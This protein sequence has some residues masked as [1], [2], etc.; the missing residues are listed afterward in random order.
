MNTCPVV[1][2]ELIDKLEKEQLKIKQE[3]QQTSV[4]SSSKM[5]NSQQK[6]LKNVMSSKQEPFIPSHHMPMQESQK[7]SVSLNNSS[8]KPILLQNTSQ[9]NKSVNSSTNCHISVTLSQTCQA[10][11]DLPL[12]SSDQSF[13]I[14]S[15]DGSELIQGISSLV[16]TM[17]KGSAMLTMAQSIQGKDALAYLQS[18]LLSE[19]NTSVEDMLRLN[20]ST[21]EMTTSSTM[22]NHGLQNSS[23]ECLSHSDMKLELNKQQQIES[24]SNSCQDTGVVKASV[25][26]TY[27]EQPTNSY[28][29]NAI[30][31]QKSMDNTSG[32][33]PMLNS[34]CIQEHQSSQHSLMPL[35]EDTEAL[36]QSK[37]SSNSQQTQNKGME[38]LNTLPPPMLI[39]HA[40][41]NTTSKK[42]ENSPI[43]K[44]QK[45]DLK[46]KEQKGESK[47]DYS[48]HTTIA[49]PGM[50]LVYNSYSCTIP[51]AEKEPELMQDS[52][53]KLNESSTTED[54]NSDC[55][56]ETISGQQI[57]MELTKEQLEKLKESSS[58][59]L[60]G[61]PFKKLG[62]AALTKT[63]KPI[64]K[65][66]HYL[67]RSFMATKKNT[68][69]SVPK[70][71][72]KTSYAKM[73]SLML[74]RMHAAKDVSAG[75]AFNF[76]DQALSF[77]QAALDP[78]HIPTYRCDGIVDSTTDPTRTF[79]SYSNVSIKLA[80]FNW[81]NYTNSE[82]K[83][84]TPSSPS[85][86]SL[87]FVQAGIPGVDL[88][89]LAAGQVSSTPL[90]GYFV[91]TN[92]I[93]SYENRYGCRLVGRSMTLTNI[94][95]Q[96]YRGGY[97]PCYS[98]SQTVKHINVGD[99]ADYDQWF[100]DLKN[101]AQNTVDGYEASRGVYAVLKPINQS[102]YLQFNQ[103]DDAEAFYFSYPSS[104]LSAADFPVNLVNAATAPKWL[105][106]NANIVA[107]QP[108]KPITSFNDVNWNISVKYSSLIEY[109]VPHALG[110]D[111]VINYPPALS[112][113]FG[114][115]QYL[116][117]FYPASY[118]DFAQLSKKILE[119]YNR[120]SQF[121]DA[122]AGV[123]PNGSMILNAAKTA[124]GLFARTGRKQLKRTI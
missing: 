88:I 84:T 35:K 73:S 120:N 105:A 86:D 91:V 53:N 42:K 103:I 59:G 62:M 102:N 119:V 104:S 65:I 118:N 21:V 6:E 69:K 67:S 92:N 95:E 19:S 110:T 10:S 15:S 99:A 112:V 66:L 2:P 17:A 101:I 45:E 108:P 33:K 29:V 96:M 100:I 31:P 72:R 75:I 27:Q 49:A 22:I 63:T 34:A 48:T 123:I 37:L 13:V 47:K 32:L 58:I 71:T 11:I 46:M 9:I 107:Y 36:D 116:P 76:P 40:T 41:Q 77:I 39:P 38:S 23:P 114:V 26:Q 122:I 87:Y 82:W 80:E 64:S 52:N 51:A 111:H 68:K 54:Q 56:V 50:P 124:L 3:Q 43:L 106:W 30:Q 74:S 93:K 55:V 79:I 115:N 117:G 70:N 109:R 98:T 97:F 20:T 4:P 28:V 60:K 14:S 85:I 89:V 61:I 78:A 8:M 24:L 94:G 12:Q 1:S 18:S 81:F 57:P 121:I 90:M 83:K 7:E 113:L 5:N 44:E 16:A 25:M